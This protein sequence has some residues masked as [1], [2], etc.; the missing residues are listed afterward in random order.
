MDLYCVICGEPWDNDCLHEVAE[1]RGHKCNEACARG[2]TEYTKI[3]AD[4]RARGCRALSPTFGTD[5]AYCVKQETDE[6]K[7]RQ[8]IIGAAYDMLGDDMDGA[9]AMLEDAGL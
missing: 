1:E 4:F 3:A 9:A 7:T 5:F 6:G 2:C 8:A